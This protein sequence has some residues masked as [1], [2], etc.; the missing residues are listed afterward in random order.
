LFANH[1]KDS[2][3]AKTKSLIEYWVI[4]VI[5]EDIEKIAEF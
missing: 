5:A 2:I 4:E 3:V 1:R